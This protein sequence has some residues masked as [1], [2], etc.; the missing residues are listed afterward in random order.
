LP[1]PH[2]PWVSGRQRPDERATRVSG[3]IDQHQKFRLDYVG[4]ITPLTTIDEI[5]HQDID[6]AN[7]SAALDVGYG[8]GVLLPRSSA[9]DWRSTYGANHAG[10]GSRYL[11]DT[12]LSSCRRLD[13]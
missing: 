2:R 12:A 1:V 3:V 11:P 13:Q 10:R 5:I 9:A 7:V 8:E 4:Q 6:D